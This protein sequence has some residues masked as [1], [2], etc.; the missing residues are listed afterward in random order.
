M[1]TTTLGAG[2]VIVTMMIALGL[3]VLCQK[4]DS[5]A[6]GANGR[7]GIASRAKATS[8]QN[9]GKANF[10]ASA[11]PEPSVLWRQ[12]REALAQAK[13][14]SD[15]DRRQQLLAAMSARISDGDLPGVVDFLNQQESVIDVVDLRALLLCR[16]AKND[17]QAAAEAALLAGAGHRQEAVNAVMGVW[18]EQ[19]LDDAIAWATAQPEGRARTDTLLTVAYDV[20]RSRPQQAVEIALK[21]PA[22]AAGDDLLV[23]AASQWAVTAPLEVVAWVREVGDEAL[24]ARLMAAVAATLGDSAPVSAADIALHEMPPGRAQNDALVAIVQRWAQEEPRAAADWVA[25]FPE[26]ALRDAAMDNLVKLWTAR[27]QDSPD[28]WIDTLAA[29]PGRDSAVRA[30][31]EQ[32]APLSPEAAA[33]WAEGITDQ[34]LRE[35][36]LGRVIAVWM[37]MDSKAAKAW[38]DRSPLSSGTKNLLLSQGKNT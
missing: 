5:A 26:G 20:A 21:L 25:R 35:A 23:H 4:A 16:W 15:V 31:S 1:K 7:A 28:S 13:C 34:K 17:P 33:G 29:G 37:K 30:Y 18:T 32:L 19:R 36:Q 3:D 8:V 24:R 27:G 6:Q 9:A 38:V 22:S 2:A 12:L 10:G 14:E 11:R